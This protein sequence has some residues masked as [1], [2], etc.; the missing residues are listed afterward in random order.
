MPSAPL[1]YCAEPGCPERT[2]TARC[3]RHTQQQKQHV[4]RHYS[5]PGVNYGRRWNTARLEHLSEQ[6]FCVACKALGRETLATEVDHRIPH[7]GDAT[8]FWDRLNWQSLCRSCHSSKTRREQM[9]GA[10]AL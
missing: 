9:A 8:R 7:C 2:A 4:R 1:R 5:G 6:P 10:L 3:K